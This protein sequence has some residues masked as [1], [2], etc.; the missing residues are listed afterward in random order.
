MDGSDL[1]GVFTL[2]T[3]H[4]SLN[5]KDYLHHQKPV[6]AAV[7]GGGYI[8]LEMA[9]SLLEQGC[10]VSIIERAP[11]IIPNMDEDMALIVTNYLQSKGVKVYTDTAVAGFSGEQRVTMVNTDKGPIEADFVLLSIGVLPNGEIAAKAGIKLGIRGAIRVNDRMETNIKTFLLPATA[12]PQDL[13]SGKKSI[14]P[15]APPPQAGEGRREKC[16]C[17]QASFKGVLGLELPGIEMEISG[18]DLS[19]GMPPAWA[20]IIIAKRS[21]PIVPHIIARHNVKFTSSSC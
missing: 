14:S 18:P 7:I 5:I 3:I 9:E 2:R 16:R 6:K 19:E 11:H 10:E 15:W 1:K 4:D 17:G 8:G 20:L 12:P 21:R 13:I